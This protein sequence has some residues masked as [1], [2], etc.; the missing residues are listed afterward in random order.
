MHSTKNAHYSLI[1]G[2]IKAFL[3]RHEITTQTLC[4]RDSFPVTQTYRSTSHIYVY[5]VSNCVQKNQNIRTDMTNSFIGAKRKNHVTLLLSLSPFRSSH[6]CVRVL[7]MDSLWLRV[8]HSSHR[9]SLYSIT[10]TSSNNKCVEH[11]N[12]HERGKEN[13]PLEYMTKCF[14]ENY[15]L[16]RSIFL[17]WWFSSFSV[18]V[19]VCCLVHISG[20][21]TETSFSHIMYKWIYVQICVASKSHEIIESF[22]W[23][24]YRNGSTIL[25]KCAFFPFLSRFR[26][27]DSFRNRMKTKRNE[28][29]NAKMLEKTKCNNK[30]FAITLGQNVLWIYRCV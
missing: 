12:V 19:Y 15:L 26:E 13:G 3:R 23:D 14:Q 17:W 16:F 5:R 4:P 18:L 24:M 20:S 11:E 2:L 25:H 1:W 22:M 9:Q 27:S 29:F 21:S 10:T 6:W 30:V 8:L 28:K 7:G